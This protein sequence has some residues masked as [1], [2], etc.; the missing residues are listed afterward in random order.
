MS[1]NPKC[2]PLLAA[3]LLAA[4]LLAALPSAALAANSGGNLV[5]APL[6][7][8]YVGFG[9]NVTVDTHQ[10][11]SDTIEHVIGGYNDSGNV[12]GK[13][14]TINQA[15]YTKLQLKNVYGGYSRG[16]NADG[17]EVTINAGMLDYVFGGNSE[18]DAANNNTVTINAGTV[19]YVYGG[20]GATGAS[21]NT[22]IIAREFTGSGDVVGGWA[23]A[24]KAT[25]NTVVLAPGIAANTYFARAFYG[26]YDGGTADDLFTGNT[27]EVWSKGISVVSVKNFE[28]YHFI[29]PANIQAGE[30]MLTIT[31]G[32]TQFEGPINV[33]VAVA[34]GTQSLKAGD[35][36]TLIRNTKGLQNSQGNQLEQGADYRQVSLTG[37]QGISLEYVFTLDNDE[38]TLVATV[39]AIG[40]PADA[41]SSPGV[42]AAGAGAAAPVQAARIRPE[43]KAVLESRVGAATFL[44]NAGDLASTSIGQLYIAAQ[45][46]APDGKTAASGNASASGEVTA[47]AVTAG[48]NNLT[49]GEVT[50]GSGKAK[51]GS[52]EATAA[53]GK[54]EA[55]PVA[56]TGSASYSTFASTSAARQ[57]FKT[58]SHVD[59]GGFSGLAG[60]S[61]RARFGRAEFLAGAFFE[62]G[63]ASMD[64]H[65]SFPSGDVDGS[66]HSSYVGG[67]VLARL[68][69]ARGALSGA[70]A[71]GSLRAG[72]MNSDWRSEDLRDAATGRRAEYDLNTPYVG[73]H[74]GLG[75]VLPLADNLDADLYGKYFWT[76]LRGDDALVAFDRYDFDDADSSRLRVGTRLDWR[77]GARA[78]LHVG[79]AWEREFAGEINA[80]TYGL[81][82]PSPSMEGDSGLFDLGLTLAPASLPNLGLG[83]GVTG[84]AGKRRGVSGNVMLQYTF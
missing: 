3:L 35:S 78:S 67:G 56:T 54:A 12:N 37:R 39:D 6:P 31:G 55:A 25:G 48:A 62:V 7:K 71:E 28:N 10:Q 24:G 64:T 13:T 66:G 18:T 14:V 16:G 65:N 43:T 36:V 9:S 38:T 70:Y 84:Y 42:P 22:V 79:A 72:G 76:H 40:A 26:G 19:N 69:L 81:E 5:N 30:T 21:G 32:V 61:K 44:N 83:L 52:G 82:P 4:L 15:P 33:G 20:F 8:S 49:A 59:V 2:P 27:L 73:A 46:S 57:R 1:R 63:A 23:A 29:L 47:G 60:L 34:A 51:A 77:F 50:A 68:G 80:V 53:S 74:A 17:N 41:A 75:W 11:G 45:K 58:G